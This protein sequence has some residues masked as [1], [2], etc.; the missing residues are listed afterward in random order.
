MKDAKLLSII[1]LVVL[2]GIE[3]CMPHRYWRESIDRMVGTKFD[4]QKERN[5]QTTSY[6]TRKSSK[7]DDFYYRV[8]AESGNKRY[9]ILWSDSCR[10]SLLVNSNGTILSWRYEDVAYPRHDCFTY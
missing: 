10:Y 8:E 1:F 9:Y 6:Y 5:E 4:P 7:G 3:G 2:F